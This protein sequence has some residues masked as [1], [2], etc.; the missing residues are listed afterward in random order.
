MY[1]LTAA[2]DNEP[3]KRHT[4]RDKKCIE[5]ECANDR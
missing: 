5:S 4:E 1:I 2:D 3:Q